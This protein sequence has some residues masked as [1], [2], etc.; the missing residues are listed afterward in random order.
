M[1]DEIPIGG[2]CDPRFAPVREAFIGNFRE[3]SEPG[4]AV[5]LMVEGRLV[6]DLWGGWRDAA[7]QNPWARD[8]LVNFFSVGKAFT[9]LVA[10][11]LV[12]RGLLDLDA[13]AATHWP[14][15]A[16]AGKERITLRHI[17]AH[18]AGL[19]AIREPLPDGAMFDWP[20]MTAA[21]AAQTPWWEPGT[22]HG[23]HVNTFGYLAGELVRRAGGRTLGQILRDEVAGPLGADIHI[24]LPQTEHSRCAEF[25]WPSVEIPR[26][27]T[28]LDD[29]ALMKWNTY[30]N[31]PGISG[32]GWVNSSEWRTAEIPSTNGHGTA[33]GIARIYAA[34]ANGGAIDGVEILSPAMLTEATTEQSFGRDR[35][36]D[37][38][39]RFALGFQLPQAERRLG[40]N[41][42]AFGHFGAGGSLGFCDPQ[43]RV[44]F[45]YVT[46]DMGPRWQNPRNRALI[47]AIYE[48]L[49]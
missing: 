8:T 6:A 13:P 30:W 49:A 23:Y 37:R 4:G 28:S 2:T 27:E 24:G 29:D 18:Q 40:P 5:A 32:A 14:E 45:A 9:S 15:F 25:L 1:K 19:P 16:A 36:L 3:R 12:E 10:L 33:R 48:S 38:E 11:R 46:N 31:P 20:R 41:D 39:S 47:E 17:L 43:A 7:R 22:A 26:P 34:L 35:I 44:A 21:L 42:V